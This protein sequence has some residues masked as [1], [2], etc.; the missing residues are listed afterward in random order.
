M[1]T[2]NEDIIAK[3][4]EKYKGHAV[5][6]LP[7]T[8][9]YYQHIIQ[10]NRD[11]NLFLIYGGTPEIR[12]I[13]QRQHLKVILMDSSQ[14]M[15]NAMGKL[16]LS[17][18]ALAANEEVIIADWLQISDDKNYFNI[19][20][21]DDAINRVK[22]DQFELFLR[23][24]YQRMVRG[25]L[26]VCHLF[27]KPDDELINKNFSTL[28]NEYKNGLVLTVYDLASELNFICFNK[29]TYEMGPP[30]TIKHLGKKKLDLFKPG[31]DFI[32]LFDYFD[33]HFCC[34]PQNEFEKLVEKYFSIVEIFY[35][36]EYHYG[37]FKPL[38]LLKKR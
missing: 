2:S 22:W 5:R 15:I 1:L 26:F 11:I 31:L 32:K 6:P 19:V 10:A 30:Q 24:T 38:Y 16:T 25:G 20:M 23:N 7:S 33:S 28:M 37:V 8:I 21:G 34:P 12:S 3:E 27:V 17:Q 35:P 14:H 18:T 29:L 9:E 13:C 4:W 36:H